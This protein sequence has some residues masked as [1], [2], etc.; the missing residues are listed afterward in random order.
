MTILSIPIPVLL[1]VLLA[2]LVQSSVGFGYALVT[3]PALLL[4][5]E[6]KT[7]VLVALLTSAVLNAL[8]VSGT[9]RKADGR[10]VLPL[11]AASSL[12]TIPGAYV[13]KVVNADVL[14]LWVEAAVFA[15]AIVMLTGKRLRFRNERLA[16]LAAGFGSGVLGSSTG[17]SGPPVVLCLV[18]QGYRR[19]VF[20]ASLGTFFLMNNLVALAI[21]ARTGSLTWGIARL[22]FALVPAQAAGF[23]IGLQLLPRLKENIFRRVVVG[24]VMAS[25]FINVIICL[26]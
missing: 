7:V 12:G 17:M 1:T 6:P 4:I 15:T 3:V 21:H 18:D 16:R 14:K 10:I 24:I 9:W 13:L 2:A 26:R 22:G 25:G 5:L 11:I 19:E 8:I 23:A 20:R